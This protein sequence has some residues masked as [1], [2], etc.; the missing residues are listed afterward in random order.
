MS[1]YSKSIFRAIAKTFKQESVHFDADEEYGI[2]DGFFHNDHPAF[3]I[4]GVRFRARRT[5]FTV[6]GCAE[7][8]FDP[9]NKELMQRLMEFLCRAND[10]LYFGN[11]KASFSDN[12]VYFYN[13]V[14]CSGLNAPTPDMIKLELEIVCKIWERVADGLNAVLNEGA[15]AKTAADLCEFL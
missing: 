12:E 10:K 14:D 8:K 3:P 13:F 2:F 6:Q 15:D 5:S 7:A 1:N 11:F 4:I 9:Q